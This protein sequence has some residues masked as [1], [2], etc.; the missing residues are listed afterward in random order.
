MMM[1]NR[2][3]G[4]VLV[5]CWMG[6]CTEVPSAR[7]QHGD[8]GTGS[9][10]AGSGGPGDPVCQT[11]SATAEGQVV[12]GD[13][14][15]MAHVQV[16]VGGCTA[17]SDG[18]G[19]Y[20]LANIPVAVRQ[21]INFRLSGY[22]PLSYA[23]TIKA[24]ST[25]YVEATMVASTYHKVTGSG[26]AIHNDLAEVPGGHYLDRAGRSYTRPV[27]V[28]TD[29][30]EPS[31]AMAKH[32]FPGTTD[33]KDKAGKAV[34]FVSYGVVAVHAWSDDKTTILRNS[35]GMA[36]TF[37]MNADATEATLSLFFYDEQQGIW[38]E[39]GEAQR[40]ADGSYASQVSRVGSWSLSKA[41]RVPPGIYK[42]RIVYENKEPA[43]DIRVFAVGKNWLAE[44]LST[45]S[46]GRFELHVVPDAEFKLEAYDCTKKYAA[47]YADPIPGIAS[48]EIVDD[49]T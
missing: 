6:A 47:A 23:L 1:W 9:W 19:Y 24:G 34:Q 29:Y 40:Q 44:A 5:A 8:G 28:D 26:E 25:N 14:V 46:D 16:D 38:T 4:L 35:G 13:G 36:I 15:E 43:Q 7:G 2:A 39:K 32:Y 27:V 3:M 10:D 33:G 22:F 20:T 41:V 42:G 17:M 21:H 31:V 18:A 37:P 30:L 45:D 49:R 48:G 12:D 11:G